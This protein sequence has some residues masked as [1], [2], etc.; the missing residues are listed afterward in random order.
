MIRAVDVPDLDG[1]ESNQRLLT[2]LKAERDLIEAASTWPWAP[3]TVRTIA[4][5]LLLPILLLATSRAFDAWL[6]G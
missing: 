6:G 3:G 5:T 4:T 2:A 1:V